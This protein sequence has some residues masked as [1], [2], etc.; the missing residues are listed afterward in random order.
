MGD[1]FVGELGR[2]CKMWYNYGS[3]D[4]LNV[5]PLERVECSQ[6]LSCSDFGVKSC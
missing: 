6:L 3:M 1:R 5:V 2:T 4:V